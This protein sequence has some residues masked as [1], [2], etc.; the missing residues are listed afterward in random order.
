MMYRTRQLEQD[1]LMMEGTWK[2]N[3]VRNKAMGTRQLND[4]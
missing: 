2:F 4:G 3:D 1:N